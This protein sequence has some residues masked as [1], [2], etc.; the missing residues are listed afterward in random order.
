MAELDRFDAWTRELPGMTAPASCAMLFDLR[1]RRDQ[2]TKNEE[3]RRLRMEPQEYVRFESRRGESQKAELRAFIVR[4]AGP[5]G[6]RLFPC[7]VDCASVDAY[8]RFQVCL[9]LR[10]PETV[11]DLRKGSLKSAIEEFLPKVREMRA[12]NSAYLKRCGRCFLKS[13]CLQCPAKAWAEHGTLDTPV[14]YFCRITHAQAVSIGLLDEGEKAWTLTDWQAR[15]TERA[16]S[17]KNGSGA[18]PEGSEEYEG[19]KRWRAR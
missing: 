15:V 7:L 18:R 16:A 17:W 13:L 2:E 1:S 12:A 4:F 6:D 19:E 3:I 14:E 9:S 11:Y 8:G 10:H 5:G